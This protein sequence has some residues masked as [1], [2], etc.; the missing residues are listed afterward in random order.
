MAVLRG[1]VLRERADRCTPPL[2]LLEN[3]EKKPGNV[4]LFSWLLVTGQG[5]KKTLKG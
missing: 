4:G 5:A 2:G 3:H 1:D